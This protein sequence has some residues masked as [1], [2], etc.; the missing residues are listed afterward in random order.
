MGFSLIPREMKFFDRFDEATA[1]LCRASGKLVE[2]VT[3]FDHLDERGAD[4]KGEETRCDEIVERTL[5]DLDRSFITPFDRED[6]HSLA[7][8]LD[9]VMDAIEETAYRFCRFRVDRPT[10]AAIRM[11]Q[12]AQQCCGHFQQAIALLRDLGNSETIQ[13]HLRNISQLENEAD[14]VYRDSD[15]AL[16]ATGA[17]DLLGLIKWRE[18]YG[19]LETTVDSCKGVANVVSEIVIKGS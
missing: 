8:L 15:S 19:W 17:G 18:L 16:F 12:L 11:A 1:V 6:I 4:L 7:K 2:L 9:D 5:V 3:V 10:P 14:T 13:G